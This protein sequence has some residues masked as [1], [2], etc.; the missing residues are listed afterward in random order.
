MLENRQSTMLEPIKLLGP[1]AP[2]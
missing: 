1:A 2:L